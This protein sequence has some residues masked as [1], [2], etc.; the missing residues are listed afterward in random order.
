MRGNYKEFN[1]EKKETI[2]KIMTS[3]E[4]NKEKER[5]VTGGEIPTWTMEEE[6][7]QKTYKGSSIVEEPI[8]DV[9]MIDVVATIL[10]V[11]SI[12]NIPQVTI[13]TDTMQVDRNSKKMDTIEYPFKDYGPNVDNLVGYTRSKEEKK[14]G[15]GEKKDKERKEEVERRKIEEEKGKRK[16]KKNLRKQ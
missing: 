14:N 3:M 11:E 2:F 16:K 1:K 13:D 5:K 7:E 9:E 12:T 10:L 6:K 4:L 15:E 8:K